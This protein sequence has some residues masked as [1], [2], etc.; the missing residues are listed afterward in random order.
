M[1]GYDGTG[2]RGRGPMT[3]RGDGYCVLEMPDYPHKLGTGYVG[4]SGRQMRLPA[5]WANPATTPSFAHITRIQNALLAVERRLRNLET[6][7]HRTDGADPHAAS[8]DTEAR[9][10]RSTS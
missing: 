9:S 6:A 7:V 4:L 8:A 2:P 10:D 3:G 1:P 5:E